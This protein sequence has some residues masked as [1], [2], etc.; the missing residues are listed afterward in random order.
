ML[1]IRASVERVRFSELVVI[2]MSFAFA[3]SSQNAAGLQRSRM[4]S[5]NDILSND[6]Q[7]TLYRV[8]NILYDA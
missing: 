4:P 6:K 7:K 8:S 2:N 5:K 1:Q 3:A